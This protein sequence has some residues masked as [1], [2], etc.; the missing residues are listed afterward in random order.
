MHSSNYKIKLGVSTFRNQEHL[1]S[2]TINT[3][4]LLTLHIQDT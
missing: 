2:L 1:S 4:A 3:L